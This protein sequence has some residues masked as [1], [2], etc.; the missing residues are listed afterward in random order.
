M[1]E[2]VFEGLNLTSIHSAFEM[3]QHTLNENEGAVSMWVMSLEDLAPYP[4]QEGMS[5]GSPYFRNYPFLTDSP[6]P[7]NV[8]AGNFK[9]LFWNN[10]HPAIR[11]QFDKGNFYEEVIQIHCFYGTPFVDIRNKANIAIQT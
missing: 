6:D 3:K 4:L 8:D 7:M 2:I 1:Q 5:M 9:I 11:V 10:F